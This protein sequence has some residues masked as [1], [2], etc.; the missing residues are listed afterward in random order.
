MMAT[1][2]TGLISVACA[3]AAAVAVLF[4]PV[5]I[6]QQVDAQSN[7][8]VITGPVG[9]SPY[10]VVRGWHKPFAE[11]GFAFGGNSGVFAES[12]NRIF[13]AQRGEFRLPT[14]I[15]PE[16]AGFAGSIKMNVLTLADRRVWQNCLYTLDRNGK[17][18]ERWT[19]WDQLCEGSSGPGPH[20]LRISPYDRERR[21]WVV[22]ETFHIENEYV[23]Q[24]DPREFDSV[25]EFVIEECTRLSAL[26]TA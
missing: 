23:M 6:V 18:K 1:T 24:L 25:P 15:P 22:N 8:A 20:R 3:V 10:N 19:Q 16:F 4:A 13:V 21:V 26:M 2:R 12:P 17:V 14:P 5:T 7:Q 11:P 9:P